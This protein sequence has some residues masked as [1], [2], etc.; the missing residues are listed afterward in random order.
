MGAAGVSAAEAVRESDD[1]ADILLL[2]DDSYGYYSRPGLAYYLTGEVSQSWLFPFDKGDFERLNLRRQTALVKSL[3][4]DSHQVELGTGERLSYDRLLLATGSSA[5]FPPLPGVDLRG[6]VKLDDLADARGILSLV[7][8]ARAAVVIG[9]GITALEIVEGL[10][11]RRV[12]THYF[13]RQDRYWGNVL[14]EMESQIVQHRLTDGGVELHFHTEAA[15]ILGR[16]GRVAGVQ[17]KDGRQIDCGLVAIAI[18]VRPRVDLARTANLEIDRGILV[19]EHL[20]S[21]SPDVLAAGDVAQVYDPL[22]G[23][24]VLDTLWGVAVAQGR[25]AGRNLA[26]ISTAYRKAIPFNV[27]RLAGLTTTII[28]MVGRGGDSDLLGIARGDSETWRQLPDA[29]IAQRD[30]EINRLRV[31]IGGD[32]LIGAIVMGDQTLSQPLHHLIS[33]QVNIAA[34][35]DELLDPDG[36]LAGS[37]VQLWTEWRKSNAPTGS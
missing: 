18:G 10:R 26:G 13:L 29:M 31:L 27:T 30:F 3:R 5:V 8:G 24:S 37:L 11:S 4:P 15:Q 6:V 19:N 9:G 35:R 32:R 7:R 33:H 12:K 14:D 20:E 21:S 2:S 28:G 16:R 17:T 1:S 25:A 22:S 23:R 34:I 36:R